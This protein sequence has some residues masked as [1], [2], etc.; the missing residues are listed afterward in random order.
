MNPNFIPQHIHPKTSSETSLWF[1]LQKFRL[2][3]IARETESRIPS[4]ADIKNVDLPLTRPHYL[5]YLDEESDRHCYA[6]ELP[7]GVETPD[8]MIFQ[9]LR[10][11]YGRLPDN[12]LWLG[13]RALHIIHWDRTH[14]YC[15]RCGTKT[16]PHEQERARQCPECGQTTYPR[17]SP[18]VIMRVT[19]QGKYGPEILLAR[20]PRH[21]HGF[22]SVL[23]GFVEPGETL[24]TCVRR[25]IREEVGIEV[26]NVRYFGSQPWPFPDSLM[27]AFTAEYTNGKIIPEEGEIED[28]RW[29]TPDNLPKLPTPMSISRQLIDDY[30]A[31]F[32][33]GE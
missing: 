31:Q 21:Y 12:M 29:F 13:G 9:G 10:G 18:A 16:E 1:I 27:I 23:A 25:E 5:G 20:G 17:I 6:A 8:G 15:G 24:E 11:L 2:L 22:Y 14:Q 33:D 28:A 7:E 4:Q 3:V 30:L 32:S 19:R 26:S